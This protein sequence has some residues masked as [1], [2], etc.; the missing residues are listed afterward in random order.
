VAVAA[1]LIETLLVVL[2]VEDKAGKALLAQL[3]ALPIQA[4][5]AVVKTATDKQVAL[6]SLLFATKHKEITWHI[7]QK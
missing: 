1:Q 4:V 2:V 3:L 7:L 6:A 5:V